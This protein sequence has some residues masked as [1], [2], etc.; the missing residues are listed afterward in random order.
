[1]ISQSHLNLLGLF[2][3]FN[4][5]K[6]GGIEESARVAWN[7]V[8]SEIKS[9]GGHATLFSFGEVPEN[10]GAGNE[11]FIYAHSKYSAVVRA[12]R[13]RED[14]HA[15]LVW[16]VGL[17]K[18]I[19]FFRCP[20]AKVVVFLHGIEVW[21]SLDFLTT[22]LLKRSIIFLSNTDYTWNRF[23]AFHPHL[24]SK[25]QK[26]VHLGLQI[27]LQTPPPE[28]GDNPVALMIGRLSKSEDYKGHR[29]MI[30]AWT[31]V[32]KRI[33]TAKLWIVG[34]GD[35]RPRLE[36]LVSERGL[37]ERVVFWGQVSEQ[38]KQEL[39]AYSRCLA[40]PSRGEGF[41]LVYLEAMRFGRPCLVS[42]ADAG[43]EVVNPPEA[44]L[45]ANT[46]HPEHLA[47]AVCSLLSYGQEWQ[48]LSVRSRR[49][50]EEFFTAK[51][52]QSRLIS[53]LFNSATVL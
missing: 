9:R 13:S 44:G 50:Y 19:P 25:K 47:D 53:A 12:F 20:K 28:P 3:A 15:I 22:A 43:R 31:M 48:E 5:G 34:D 49:R 10:N 36:L 27:P 45:S 38:K 23:K 26:T 39:L 24:S 16:H 37:G 29:E 42:N 11:Q 18:L 52:F 7:A 14:F 30:N 33:P 8:S 4:S 40:L 32:L 21:K 6:I 17:L 41:G 51:H 2:P 1:M 46:D 35:L